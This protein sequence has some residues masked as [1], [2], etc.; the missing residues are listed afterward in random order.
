MNLITLARGLKTRLLE[1]IHF[2]SPN[3]QPRALVR[4]RV[5]SLTF[6]AGTT[7]RQAYKARVNNLV[8]NPR[9][10]GFLCALALLRNTLS[11]RQCPRLLAYCAPRG[12]YETG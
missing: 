8:N 1:F 4:G 12:S 3:Y 9:S 2:I 5:P 6:G 10:A 7:S 11:A